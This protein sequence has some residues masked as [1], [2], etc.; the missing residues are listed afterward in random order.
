MTDGIE[1]RKR[2]SLKTKKP[3]LPKAKVPDNDSNGN[4]CKKRKISSAS[5][6][7]NLLKSIP[8]RH[9]PE[10]ICLSDEETSNCKEVKLRNT[11]TAASSILDIPD[12]Q[13]REVRR[14]LLALREQ[15]SCMAYIQQLPELELPEK[16]KVSGARESTP[17][18]SLA[19]SDQ[20]YSPLPQMCSACAHRKPISHNFDSLINSIINSPH[21]DNNSSDCKS[22]KILKTE[23]CPTKLSTLSSDCDRSGDAVV[24][25]KSPVLDFDIMSDFEDDI[26][27]SNIEER[28]EI[29]NCEKGKLDVKTTDET[30]K[31]GPSSSVDVDTSA[32]VCGG[33]ILSAC[34][35]CNMEFEKGTSQLDIDGH[36]AACLSA[37]GDDATW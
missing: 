34:P 28:D 29:K 21:N 2:L 26:L 33:H 35:L 22:P 3:T 25:S 16:E 18:T 6:D 17:V 20:E 12:E 13:L 32:P 36:I 5:V 23:S 31:D 7:L 11:D 4:V 19:S 10:I 15:G 8:E 24:A 9:E 30:L 37:A 1:K 14:Q 27:M